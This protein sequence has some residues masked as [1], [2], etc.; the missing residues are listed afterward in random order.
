MSDTFNCSFTHIIFSTKDR[1]TFI[2]G[3]IKERIYPFII[4]ISR[5]LKCKVLVVNGTEDHIHILVKLHPQ[6]SISEYTRIIKSNTSRFVNEEVRP[7]YGRFE[8][9]AGYSC[10]S[11]SYS[12]VPTL[13][14]YI[15]N[16]DAHHLKYTFQEEISNI[17]NKTAQEPDF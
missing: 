13:V 8:W 11:V 7:T 14:N 9:Q 15:R 10:F 3:Y 5:N 16:Q 4:A 17:L 1:K 12:I 6:K 2:K